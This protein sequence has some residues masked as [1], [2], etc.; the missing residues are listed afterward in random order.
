MINSNKISSYSLLIGFVVSISSCIQD[1]KNRIVLGENYAKTELINS[2]KDTTLHN[3]VNFEYLIIKNKQ[4]AIKF[5]ETVLF[6]IYGRINI[7]K[8]RPYEAYY[9]S[10][11][12]VIIGTLPQ[13]SHGGTF[14]IIIDSRNCKIVRITH[15]K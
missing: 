11:Y 4:E 15:G 1:S 10:N 14:M 8:Q 12:W 5:A 13:G 6:E 3:V 9:I 2:L 7:I